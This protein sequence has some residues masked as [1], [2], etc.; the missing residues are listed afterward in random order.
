MNCIVTAGLRHEHVPSSKGH[1][2]G[3]K[4]SP[5]HFQT[6]S[7]QAKITGDGI[8]ELNGNNVRPAL[9]FYALSCQQTAVMSLW[10][11]L[12]R[13]GEEGGSSAHNVGQR[14]KRRHRRAASDVWR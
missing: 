11:L 7:D 5:R 14:G 1:R 12:I 13:R 8:I 9:F 2:R 10:G 3:L 6:S 4:H